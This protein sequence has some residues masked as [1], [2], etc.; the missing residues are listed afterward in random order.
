MGKDRAKTRRKDDMEEDEPPKGKGKDRSKSK[1]AHE[2]DHKRESKEEPQKKDSKNKKAHLDF[3]DHD[4]DLRSTKS[5]RGRSQGDSDEDDD[6]RK[7]HLKFIN[8]ESADGAQDDHSDTPQKRSKKDMPFSPFNPPPQSSIRILLEDYL[9]KKTQP[10]LLGP[11]WILRYFV[12]TNSDQEGNQA[13]LYYDNIKERTGVASGVIPFQYIKSIERQKPERVPKKGEEKFG[14]ECKFSINMQAE[15]SGRLWELAAETKEKADLWVQTLQKEL[16]QFR[17][18]EIEREKERE[19]QKQVRELRERERAKKKKDDEE[20]SLD[21]F[22]W[23][24]VTKKKKRRRDLMP[25]KPH[26]E[27]HDEKKDEPEK[28]SHHSKAWKSATF[29][30]KFKITEDAA[31]PATASRPAMHDTSP[32]HSDE[33]NSSSPKEQKN[34]GPPPPEQQ[35]PAVY[36]P[37]TD[38]AR[39]FGG[40]CPKPPCC[41]VN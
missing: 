17:I 33:Q 31:T 11:R 24:P 40:R 41:I 19:A 38:P 20:K 30:L 9:K 29:R 12:L 22:V 28:R 8:A 18:D 36:D 7:A 6:A 37:A 35:A 2:D 32:D 14:E 13:V 1:E 27:N 34:G 3:I 23:D 26:E 5:Q 25:Q 39:C 4:D 15:D 21:E 16:S 10:K